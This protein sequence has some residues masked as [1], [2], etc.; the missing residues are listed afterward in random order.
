MFSTIR[1]HL[2]LSPAGAIA[3]IALVFAMAGGAFA[4][5]N[6][7]HGATASAKA[8]RGPKGPKGATGPA[9]AQGPAGPAGPAGAAGKNGTNGEDGENGAKGATGA[10][11]AT[12]VTGLEGSPWTVGSKLPSG[13]T[14]RGAFAAADA[15]L[16]GVQWVPVSFPIPL[17]NGLD[18]EHVHVIGVGGT[19]EEGCTGGKQGEP[20]A[21]PG[22]LCVYLSQVGGA[23][24]E[25]LGITNPENESG[26]VFPGAGRSG[27]T[28]AALFEPKGQ[29]VG[30]WV[31][32]AP[33]P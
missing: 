5:N 16:A 27:A 12:G 7:G 25:V 22:N 32:T 18:A 10:A 2:R 21:E 15:G 3:V 30:T 31:V 24:G 8:K 26:L 6:G 23:E 1:R 33:A 13:A 19:G 14:E 28:L 20:K 17:A 9:G 29:L 4:A 11:G